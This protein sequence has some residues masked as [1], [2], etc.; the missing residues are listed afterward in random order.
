MAAEYIGTFVLKGMDELLEQPGWKI[1]RYGKSLRHELRNDYIHRLSFGLF[2]E[3]VKVYRVT[4]ELISVYDIMPGYFD[5]DDP[6]NRE[7]IYY[8]SD[9][10]DMVLEG[11]E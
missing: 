8:L 3:K 9:Y 11:D 1:F 5:T 10:R 6:H 4:R 2:G 7:A